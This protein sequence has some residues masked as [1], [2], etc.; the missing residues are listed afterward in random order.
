MKRRE[1][2][3]YVDDMIQAAEDILAEVA[4]TEIE[5]FVSDRRRQKIIIRDLEVMG[6]AAGKIPNEIRKQNPGIAW[7]RM[8]AM[9][10]KFI[11]E[12]FG[13]DA[14]IIFT[15]ATEDAPKLLDEL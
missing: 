6:E 5:Q 3:D 9:R 7:S 4:G 11:H 1:L 15:T 12:Y 8:M 14:A 2:R 13:V 10:N